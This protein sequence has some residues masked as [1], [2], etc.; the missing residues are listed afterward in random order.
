METARPAAPA[1]ASVPTP[2][3]SANPGLTMLPS[4]EVRQV[5]WR[6]YER[7]DLHL[8][9]QSARGVARGPVARLVAAGARN[10]HEWTEAKA[11]L[12]PV[13]DESGITAAGLEPEQG[14]Y[15]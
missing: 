15:L 14:G 12:L 10:S 3:F 9:V 6:F 7:Y 11:S 5:L 8:L 1:S 4:D 2:G 13:F